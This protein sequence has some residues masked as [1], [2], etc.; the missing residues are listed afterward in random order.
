MSW[1]LAMF[2]LVLGL[3]VIDKGVF[4]Q[5]TRQVT[6]Q[7]PLQVR[8]ADTSIVINKARRLLILYTHGV[9]VMVYPVA[10][11]FNPRGHKQRSGDGRTPE[12]S[13]VI[14]EMLHQNLARRYGARSLRLSYP[15][16]ADAR[17]GLRRGLITERQYRRIVSL[18]KQGKTPLQ[19]TRLGGS[20]RIHGGGVGRNWTLGCAAMRDADIIELYRVV[21]VGTPVR[22][23][24]SKTPG[25]SD[26]DGIPDQLDILIGAKKLALNKAR[27]GTGYMRLKY[28]M[29]DVPKDKGVCTD[30]VIR[31]FRNAGI[32]LQVVLHRHIG[33]NPRRYR[34]IRRRDPNIDQRRV[35]NLI[36]LF[37]SRYQLISTGITLANRANYL[38]GDVVFMDTLPKR[39]PDHI[40]II[41]DRVGKNGYPLVIN[42]WT[43]G[44]VTSAMALL[45]GVKVTHQFRPVTPSR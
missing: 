12:G 40:G 32:D 3:G 18:L 28:P 7:I 45:P 44:Y 25:D 9:P 24:A 17:S 27:Y 16:H 39:G 41:S 22:V 19:T 36:V 38:P 2:A 8:A 1:T 11:G 29:G 37:K 34:W 5:Y 23:V 26:G 6:L 42:N 15:N 4:D 14:S 21:K 43:H 20:I 31:A 30:V 13:Y 35:R 10:F 33:R